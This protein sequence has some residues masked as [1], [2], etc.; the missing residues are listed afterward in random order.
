MGSVIKLLTPSSRD[1]N[2]E[3]NAW[4]RSIPQH[5]KELVFVVKRFHRPEWGND[6]RKHY[7]VDVI[8][9]RLGYSLKLDGRKLIVNTCASASA[10]TTRGASSACATT[11]IRRSRCRPR[12]TS[13]PASSSRPAC[14]QRAAG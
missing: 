6:W 2:D 8:N 9:G 11:S 10:R 3:Y 4:L 13:R 1:Y 7:S 14:G 5:V 12:T